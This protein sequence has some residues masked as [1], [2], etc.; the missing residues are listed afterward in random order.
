[1]P[2]LFQLRNVLCARSL[3][4]R[5]GRV[6]GARNAMPNDIDVSNACDSWDV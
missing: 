3:R 6:G 1:M 5:I 4:G 2:A